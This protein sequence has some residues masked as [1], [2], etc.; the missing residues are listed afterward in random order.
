MKPIEG[1][2]STRVDRALASLLV[3]EVAF[4]QKWEELKHTLRTCSDYSVENCFG[5]I[6][7][8]KEGALVMNSLRKWLKQMKVIASK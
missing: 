7:T 1:E 6:D 5:A 4:H 3:K 8:E 2:I